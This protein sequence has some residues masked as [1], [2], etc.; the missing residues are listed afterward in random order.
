[1]TDVHTHTAFSPDGKSSVEEM[2]KTAFEKGAAYYGISEHFD[3]DYKTDKLRFYGGGE[4]VY[5]D[6]KLYFSRAHVLKEDYS[7]RMR[8]LVGGEFGFTE[9]PAAAP[10]YRELIENYKPD[11]VVNSV[12]TQGFFDYC[13]KGAF[14]DGKTQEIKPKGEIYRRYF[15]LVEKSIFAPYDYDVIGH[16]TYC[17]RFAPYTDRRA[18]L[19]EF[20]EEIDRVLKAIISRGKILEVNSSNY[21]LTESFLPS[22]EILTRYFGL[23]GR[24]V[25]F[26]SD[27]HHISRVLDK[28][29]LVV[30][31]LKRI[32][33]TYIVVPDC[34]EYIEVGI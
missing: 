34:G 8:V 32:G 9:N 13:E 14:T 11:F 6:P 18:L 15:E 17:I 22:E 26:A 23:G 30:S 3:Y 2:L 33:F 31:A 7:G 10:L 24:R 20:S 5:T 16:L 25:S 1:L 19:S 4:P 28:R 29:K 12:H 27:A 21:G